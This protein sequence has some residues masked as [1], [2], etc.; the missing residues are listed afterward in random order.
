MVQRQ[1]A[2]SQPEFKLDAVGFAARAG[3]A[4]L[5]VIVIAVLPTFFD[6]VKP[7][8]TGPW[9]FRWRACS[10]KAGAGTLM[11]VAAAR[12]SARCFSRCISRCGRRDYALRR[13][14]PCERRA[15]ITLR[16][17]LVAMRA[18]KP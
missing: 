1:V 13:L 17:P 2:A 5:L 7:I 12:K 9:S 18:R 8:R 15:L 6:T 14:R 16:P 11:P 4:T 10:T 3:V